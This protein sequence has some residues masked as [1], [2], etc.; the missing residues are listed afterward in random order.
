MRLREGREEV[1][2]WAIYTKPACESRTARRL[3]ESDITCFFPWYSARRRSSQRGRERVLA[4]PFFPRYLF[5]SAE[6]GD[7]WKV[8][9]LSEVTA[10]LGE[11]TPLMS[12][13]VDRLR[14]L[15]MVTGE[16]IPRKRRRSIYKRGD[17]LVVLAV[18]NVLYGREIRVEEVDKSGRIHAELDG[19]IRLTVTPEQV[20][21]SK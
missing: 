16:M 17:R 4:L 3:R 9:Q 18:E 6:L 11:P 12:E 20:G 1:S 15:A 8:L 13:S 2:W 10:V 21:K 7:L 14:R 5:V 19:Q